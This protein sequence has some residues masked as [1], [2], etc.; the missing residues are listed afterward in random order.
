MKIS[1]TAAIASYLLLALLLLFSFFYKL[2]HPPLYIWDEA[3]R[4]NDALQVYLRGDWFISHYDD[5][6]NTWGVKSPILLWLQA[7]CMHLFGV[8]EWAIRFPSALAAFGIGSL[9]WAFCTRYFGKPWIG[10]LAGSVFASTYAWVFNHAG[11]TGDYDALLTLFAISYCLSFFALCRTGKNKWF[12]L[13]WVFLTLAVLIKG[14]AGF[15]YLPGL[16]LFALLQ[17]RLF[18]LL[19][20]RLLYMGAAFLILTVGGYYLFREWHTP[21]FLVAVNNNEL[22]GRYLS[23]L[24]GHG[25]NFLYYFKIIV[26]WRF[27]YWIVFLLAAFVWGF[28]QPVQKIRTLTLFNFLLT[29]TFLLI[30]SSARTKLSWYEL[31]VYPLWAIQI[32]MLL[33]AIW[34]KLQQQFL[35]QKSR[36]VKH[37]V[38]T[39]LL[40]LVFSF[41]LRAIYIHHQHTRSGIPW[42]VHV[43]ERRQA[44]YLQ[45]AIRHKTDLNHYVFFYE[46]YDRH[47]AFYIKLLQAKGV[48]VQLVNTIE[49]VPAGIRVVVSETTAL[50]KLQQHFNAIPVQQQWG[51]TVFTTAPKQ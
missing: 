32:G 2:G 39:I 4:A 46:A 12:V 45:Q 18:S 10:F 16:A 33:Y 35:N 49:A 43:K 5:N 29:T 42:D 20:N 27:T 3:R 26:A 48:Q 36:V 8:G 23:Q 25:L 1:R 14:A 24:E 30:I 22:G 47:I 38:A 11:R 6:P 21:G 31:P 13:F 50:Q 51:C 28:M 34:Q 44:L 37:T 19:K 17:K 7:G 15:F 9:I 41:P 40:L